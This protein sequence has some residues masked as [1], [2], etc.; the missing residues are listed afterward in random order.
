[1]MPRCEV[2]RG[3]KI[4]LQILMGLAKTGPDGRLVFWQNQPE[5]GG[6]ICR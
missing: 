2:S 3:S 5:E 1:L 4:S 6:G